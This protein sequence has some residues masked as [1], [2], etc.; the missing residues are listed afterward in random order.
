MRQARCFNYFRVQP[1]L[2]RERRL[3]LLKKLPQPPPYLGNLNRVLLACV[4]YVGF[5]RAHNLRDTRQPLKG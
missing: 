2:F 1:M 5:A 4:K 3:P